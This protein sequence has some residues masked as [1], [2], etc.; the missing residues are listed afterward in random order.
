MLVDV[1]ISTHLG[2]I[3]SDLRL[4]LAITLPI[5]SRWTYQVVKIVAHVH[6][7]LQQL[8]VLL[9]LVL[10]GLIHHFHAKR[11]SVVASVFVI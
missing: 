4:L 6:H 5:T 11:S 1:A 7:V 8:H 9:H 10:V 2:T 3:G